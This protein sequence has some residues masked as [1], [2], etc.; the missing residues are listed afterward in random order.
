V[1]ENVFNRENAHK[2]QAIYIITN[3]INR[4]LRNQA[5]KNIRV[6]DGHDNCPLTINMGHGQ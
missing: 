5:L 6:T 2:R 4:Y 3:G 1:T